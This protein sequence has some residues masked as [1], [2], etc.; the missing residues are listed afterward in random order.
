MAIWVNPAA[1]LDAYREVSKYGHTM[2]RNL[3]G[4]GP[5][6][7]GPIAQTADGYLWL[8]TPTGLL[9]FDG[10]RS[11]RWSAPSGSALPDERVRA[12]LGSRDGTLWIGTSRGL[13]SWKDGK[14]VVHRS[15]SGKTVNAI[16]E[17]EGGTIWVGGASGAKAFVCTIGDDSSDCYGDNGSLGGAVLGLYRDASGALWAAGTD[18]IWKLKPNPV[19]SVALPTHVGALRTVTGGPNGGVVVGTRSQIL[20]VADG[21]VRPIELPKW[22]QGWLFTKA[23]RDRDGGL[24]IAAADN[25]LLHFR[26]DGVDAFTSLEGLSGDHVLGLFEDREGNVWVSTSQGLDR[27]RPMA[28]AI[29]SRHD[30]VAGR[31]A[32]VLAARDGSVW[33]ST[34]A[35]VYQ[36]DGTRISSMRP[37]RSATLFQ[38]RK[39]RIWMASQYEFG[40]MDGGQWATVPDIPK[41]TVDGIAE[42]SKGTIWIAHRNS[43]LLRLLP[44]GRVERTPWAALKNSGRV[45][46]MIVDPADDSLWLGLWSGDVMNVQEGKVGSFFS[47][48]EPDSRGVVQIRIDVDGAV[49][50]GSRESLTRINRGRL[51]KL[52]RES[53][54]PCEGAHWTLVDERSVWI[55]TPCGL[56]QLDRSEMAAWSAAADKGAS[57][58]V[59]VRMLDHWDG[60]GQPSNASAVGQIEGIQLF[61]PKAASSRD[62][63]I[64]VVTGNGIV[65]IDPLRIPT[66]ET[67]P[68]VHVEQVTSDSIPYDARDGLQLPALQRNL[69]ITYTGLSLTVPERMQF[70]YKLEGRDVDWQDAGNRR[71]AFYTDL[72]PGPYR[73]RV[74]AAN[75]SGLWNQE[76]DTLE[77]S[78]E[79]AWWQ[80][81][82]FRAACA[83]VSLL[84]LFGLYKLRVVQLSR[85]FGTTLE[86][87]VNERMRIARE[88]H[89]TLLQ[90]FHGLV[91][92]LQAA[93]QLW[94]SK[95][96]HKILEEGI[97]QAAEAV[98]EGRKAVQG[99][100]SGAMESNDLAEAIRTLG[101]VLATDP[102]SQ[103]GKFGVEVQGRPR[104]LH[105]VVRDDIFRIVGEALRNAFRHAQPRQ[106]EVE[107]RYGDRELNVRVR[108]DGKG[109]DRALVRGG[110]EGHF[111]LHG[112]RERAKLVGGKLTFWTRIDAGTAVDLS[113]PAARA[114]ADAGAATLDRVETPTG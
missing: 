98:A 24:W 47:L 109:M 23:L 51:S 83:A 61:T 82:I 110:R 112:M 88:L 76:G 20:E 93:H 49:W 31:P 13:A 40:Y 29:Y 52:G 39:G 32:S 35:A 21:V 65:A 8:G 104:S 72:S 94:P 64:W 73:F 95:D 111:G 30:G 44:D 26:A 46:T 1:A 85:R 7:I 66:N 106:V 86:A 80:T 36:F 48:R 42:D 70:R 96:G 79:P 54:L 43:G 97:D 33:V 67:P 100:R 113:V 58:K 45:S 78:I 62:G 91:L 53:G 71:Q 108:D 55:Y 15:V 77:F 103:V 9:R 2:W 37:S 17:D 57:T 90:T 56:A 107:I 102:A 6:S 38:D 69:E 74:I 3:D 34:S 25:G 114:Y 84:L 16:E 92:R 18:R 50:V 105:P 68:P 99:L 81:N 5:G 12:L 101:Q 11:V 22:A 63:R 28:A 75:S 60:V 19:S 59:K 10:V 89:D 87:R 4:F 27:F 41:G 14:L